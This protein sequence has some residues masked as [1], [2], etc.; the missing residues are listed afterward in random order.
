MIDDDQMVIAEEVADALFEGTGVVA[1]ETTLVSHGFPNPQGVE[2]ARESERVVRDAQAVPATIGVIDGVIH[3]GMSDEQ[4]IRFGEQAADVRKLGPRDIA[5]CIAQRA[6]GATT[7]GASLTI[8][9][10]AGISVMATGGIGGVHRGYPT[11]PD[12]SADLTV[13]S[14]LAVVV[15]SAGVKS[16]LDVPATCEMLETLGVPVLGWRTSTLPLFYTAEGGPPVSAQ[17]DTVED[18][19]AIALAHWRLDGAGLMV[20]QP[21]PTSLPDIEPLIA[22]A[23]QAADEAGAHGQAATPFVLGWLHE[24]SDGRTLAAN[25]DLI[26]A[27]AALGGQVAAALDIPDDPFLEDGELDDDEDFDDVD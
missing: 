20:A 11:P 8:A 17:V 24:H 21:P 12:V 2:V 4:I 5:V 25:R 22:Q 23:L 10:A 16:I 13:L 15:V 19:C 26:I 18:V 9:A 7:V 1:L 27:N 3:V 6:T 14:R